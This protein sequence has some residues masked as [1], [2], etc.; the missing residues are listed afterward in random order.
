MKF[1]PLLSSSVTAMGTAK[2]QSQVTWPD[3][4]QRK[5]RLLLSV[6]AFSDH[7][8]QPAVGAHGLKRNAAV[9]KNLTCKANI[10]QILVL[11]LCI[12]GGS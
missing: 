8:H 12:R 7:Q 1:P 5:A 6:F 3:M 11:D 9:M 10:F 4:L 2:L